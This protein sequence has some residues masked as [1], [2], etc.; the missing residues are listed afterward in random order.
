MALSLDHKTTALVLIDLQKGI[1]LRD[2]QP[3][4]TSVVIGN[5]VRLAD[6]FRKLGAPVVLVTVKVEAGIFP[7]G[8]VDSPTQLPAQ[9]PADFSQ[10]VPELGPHPGDILVV[11]HQWGAFHGTDLDVQLRRRGITTIVLGGVATNIGVES[12]ARAAHEHNYSTVFAEDATSTFSA[13][14]HEFAIKNIFPRLGRVR[15]TDEVLTALH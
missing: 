9:L 2:T 8:E 7:K 5:A 12:T 3:H 6:Q 10:I 1:A 11:K 14:F 13:A 15:S 4:S